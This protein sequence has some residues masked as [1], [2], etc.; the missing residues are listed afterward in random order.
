MS[1]NIYDKIIRSRLIAIVRGIP[2]Q[3]SLNVAQA[4]L[5]GGIDCME[6]TYNPASQEQSKDTLCSIEKIKE[7]F[8]DQITLGAG[9]VLT[10]Q[11][12]DDAIAAGAEFIISPNIN[13][14]VIERTK[15]RNKVSMPGAL[16]PTEAQIAV[17]CGADIVKMFP[18]G[19][20][21]PDYF[22]AVKSSMTHLI[23]SA[24]GGINLNNIST[25]MDAGIYIFGIGG[26]LVNQEIVQNER[27]EEITER[28]MKF[29]NAVHP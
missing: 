23:L 4:L 5:S 1:Q 10:A 28:A 11:Q 24:V 18:A 20:L 25:F 3:Q 13:P 9:T 26:S 12:V 7:H 29:S 16:T 14:K 6:I 17:E 27:Y 2:S 21:G 19:I 8:G 22:K 15:A